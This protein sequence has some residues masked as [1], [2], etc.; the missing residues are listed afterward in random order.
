MKKIF[1]T[2]M[3]LSI[4]VFALS[5]EKIY[6]AECASCHAMQGMMSQEEMSMMKKKMQS[7]TRQERMAM[8]QKM[9]KKMNNS[10]M[11]APTM[12]MV[13]MRLKKMTKSKEDFI[14]FVKDYIQNPS[15]SKGYCMPMAYKRFGTM[16]A[17]GKGMSAQEREVI[18]NWLYD[19]FKGKWG[20]SMNTKMCEGRNGKKMMKCGGKKM[21]KCGAGKCGAVQI[22]T[23]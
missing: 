16:P 20:M 4:S 14:I 12:P 3:V 21:M 6:K 5:G 15:Q 17:I 11:L 2:L 10:N 1:I 7:A 19:N 22:P 8:R 18:A 9:Q 23:H 13:S